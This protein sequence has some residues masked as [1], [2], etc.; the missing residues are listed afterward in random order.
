M[1]IAKSYI[2]KRTRFSSTIPSS[3]Y[4][5]QI[6]WLRC[7][8]LHSYPLNLSLQRKLS[9]NFQLRKTF[10]PKRQ[11]ES[12]VQPLTGHEGPEGEQV[13][14]STLPST[15]VLDGGGWSAPR[16]GR[17]TPW[18][19]PVPIVQEARWA[20]GPVWTG[21]E[22]LAP[23]GIRSPDR[24]ARSKSLYRLGYPVLRLRQIRRQIHV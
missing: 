15:S 16:P 12:K 9:E 13:Y 6:T 21:A 22:N 23:T 19:D 4:V 5:P 7:F 10:G 20:P 24:P 8:V 11:E 2:H 14:S 18:K 3:S 17:F 1:T